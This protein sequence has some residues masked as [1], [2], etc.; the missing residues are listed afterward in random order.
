MSVFT[1]KEIYAF[2]APPNDWENY[3]SSPKKYPN[4]RPHLKKELNDHN[5]RKGENFHALLIDRC[6]FENKGCFMVMKSLTS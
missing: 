3:S 2:Q 1:E 4:R 5:V 6:S